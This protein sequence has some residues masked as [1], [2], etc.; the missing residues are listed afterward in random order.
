MVYL[1]IDFGLLFGLIG[2][3]L[4]VVFLVGNFGFI[5]YLV[6]VFGIVLIVGFDGMF[7]GWD[8]Y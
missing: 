7:M 2:F 3:F 5:G 4:V 6:G 8:I 1:L